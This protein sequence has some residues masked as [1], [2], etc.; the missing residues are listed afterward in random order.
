VSAGVRVVHYLNQ[1]YGGLGG[2][3]QANAPLTARDGAL[4]PGRALQGAL[5][6][7]ATVIGTIVGGDNYVSERREEAVEAIR[8]ALR[9][10]GP[11]VL[12]AGPAFDAGRYG[13]ACAEACRAAA[14][15]GI[16]A[17]AAMHPENPGVQDLRR[18]VPIVPTGES[19]AEMVAVLGRVAPIALKLGRG[20]E[21][22]PAAAEGYL[23][24]GVRR[25]AVAERPGA[26]RAIDMIIAKVAGLP[27]RTELP[28]ELP[29][30]VAPAAPVRDLTRARLAL[31]TTGGLVPRG[32]PDRLVRGNS[33]VWHR[34]SIEGL[35]ALDASDWECVHRGFYTAIVSENPNY[36]L[37][38][39]IV[40]GRQRERAF[41]DL[42][43]WFFST[44]G[45]GT[46][47]GD[48]K[49]MG[50]EMAEE[51]RAARVD[52]ALLVAT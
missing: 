37:P 5:G 6:A 14:D 50:T 7:D 11:D 9:R 28:I 48:A 29:E 23:P 32:N 2:E 45:V 21:L 52:A 34:Y 40:R 3:E 25:I 10:L 16:P 36:I 1:F 43:P 38:L 33:K 15:L 31:I 47:V 18:R 39:D 41:A 17:V 26:E 4:G 35:A 44:S 42:Y 24:R 22:G 12:V 20:E 49:R 13:L 30:R 8:A 27:F 46:A 19:A 51:L